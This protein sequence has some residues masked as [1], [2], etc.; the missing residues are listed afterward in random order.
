MA[1]DRWLLAAVLLLAGGLA[2]HARFV[3]DDAFIVFQYAR[4]LVEGDG[5]SWFGERVEGYTNFGWVIWLALGFALGA[6]PVA[7]SQ[8]SGIAAF[9][10]SVALLWRIA[11]DAAEGESALVPLVATLGFATNFS[12]H[13][14]AT[15]GLATMAQTALV[16]ATFR[17]AQ[18][19][20]DAPGGPRRHFALASVWAALSLL[21]RLDSAVLLAPIGVWLLLSLRSV[22][23]ARRGDAVAALLVPVA[24]IIGV[25][26]GWKLLYYGSV[27]PNSFAA[28]LTGGGWVADGAL[29]W[30]RFV[31]WYGVG[32]LIALFTIQ[33]A[34][35]GKVPG[36]CGRAVLWVAS[37]LLASS[38]AYLTFAGGDFMEFRFLVPVAAYA[39]LALALLLDAGCARFG[40]RGRGVVAAVTVSLLSL[41]S[42]AHSI[43]F[44]TDPDLRMDGIPQL[45]DFY[46]RY[47]DGAWD[48]IGSAL[49][50]ELAGTDA[51]IAVT[52]AGAIPYYS[53]LESVDLW[54][55]NDRTIPTLGVVSEQRRPGHRYR[56]TFDYLRERGV[57]LIVGDPALLTLEELRRARIPAL[58]RGWAAMA[59]PARL[60][61][62]DEMFVVAMP[63]EADTRLL[64]WVLQPNAAIERA[65]RDWR[66]WRIPYRP[67]E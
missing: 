3:L 60:P 57:Q 31:L 45:G 26:F 11:S 1:R 32:P 17:S 66:R 38:F 56:A 15:G 37:A 40:A 48:R 39:Y 12:V 16:L 29:Q 19:C 10:F 34:L 41:S 2:W 53:R 47:P 20:W 14:F 23:R 54:G 63:V 49:A 27:L 42:Y 6:E 67:S 25:W 36:R 8:A 64:L 58:L 50:R 18:R 4:S 24:L 7:W 22:G 21:V 52:A 61:G 46:G 51:V 9:G 33:A 13:S 5:L 44:H 59:M 28:K 30:G 35:A 55:L 65:A 43:T 62:P